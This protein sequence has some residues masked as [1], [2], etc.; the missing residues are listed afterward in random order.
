M[1]RTRNRLGASGWDRIMLGTRG[2]LLHEVY[3]PAELQNGGG[4]YLFAADHDGRGVFGRWLDV[5]YM[6]RLLQTH[7]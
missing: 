4:C 7:S 1:D 3:V 2:E 6:Q 5:I